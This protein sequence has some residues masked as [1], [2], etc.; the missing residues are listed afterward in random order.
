VTDRPTALFLIDVDGPLNPWQAKPSKRPD[1]YQTHRMRPAGW[2]N[3]W[4]KPLRVWLNP[5]HGAALLKLPGTLV[6]A[7]TWAHEANEWIGPHLGLPE[8]PVITWPDEKTPSSPY[9]KAPPAVH[10]KTKAIVEYA[11]GRPFA[12]VD[13]ELTNLDR[14]YVKRH[15]ADPA[16][17][18]HVSPRLGLL[19]EDFETL[20]VWAH[21]LNHEEQQ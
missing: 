10:W 17:L 20:T 15:H 2:E 14:D 11:A 19:A 21:G 4:Q 3:P 12:W 9:W 8:L 16:L 5:S 6:W 18:H 7:T 13:D 1:G